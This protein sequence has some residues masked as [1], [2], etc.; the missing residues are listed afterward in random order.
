MDS[1]TD[2]RMDSW[3]DGRTVGGTDK[4]DAPFEWSHY[5]FEL[6]GLHKKH[7]FLKKVAEVDNK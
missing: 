1:G 3:R 6:P 4:P 5:T 2:R 7:N